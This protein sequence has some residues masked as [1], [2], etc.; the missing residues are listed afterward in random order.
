MPLHYQKTSIKDLGK[1]DKEIKN[2]IAS[3]QKQP[4][5]LMFQ[6]ANIQSCLHYFE[7]DQEY[8]MQT[9]ENYYTPSTP[10]SPPSDHS[11]TPPQ[12]CLDLPFCKLWFQVSYQLY[13]QTIRGH[14]VT[15]PT[16]H[17]D[18]IIIP[19]ILVGEIKQITT[20]LSLNY[21]L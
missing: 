7:M 21:I 13:H 16:I 19:L 3:L 20:P 11:P 9:V 18:W 6:K 14:S 10:S 8:F 5:K 12:F 17:T 4:N 2:S 1:K 15:V